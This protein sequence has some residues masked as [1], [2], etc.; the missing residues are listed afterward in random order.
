MRECVNACDFWQAPCCPELP[1]REVFCEEYNPASK[2]ACRKAL[3]KLVFSAKTLQ[4]E[5][6]WPFNMDFAP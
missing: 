1:V 5:S 4:K 6:N 2:I 3:L